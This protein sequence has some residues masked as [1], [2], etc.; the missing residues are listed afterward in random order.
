MDLLTTRSSI[1]KRLENDTSSNYNYLPSDKYT[2]FSPTATMNSSSFTNDNDIPKD[3]STPQQLSSWII[4]LIVTIS[5][6]FFLL[7]LSC[8]YCLFRQYRIQVNNKKRRRNDSNL[9]PFAVLSRT[10]MTTKNHNNSISS[11]VNNKSNA[12]SVFSVTH[13]S[14]QVEKPKKGL[15]IRLK[16]LTPLYLLSKEKRVK[17]YPGNDPLINMNDATYC[18]NILVSSPPSNNNNLEDIKHQKKT[19]SPGS[20]IYSINKNT[21]SAGNNKILSCISKPGNTNKSG[22]RPSVSFAE[23]PEVTLIRDRQSINQRQSR[24]IKPQFR[25]SIESEREEYENDDNDDESLDDFC[26]DS[27]PTITLKDILN[28]INCDNSIARE[29]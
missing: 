17:T 3:D 1:L 25:E 18:N 22:I 24:F 7:L 28:M 5:F 6:V 26:D 29:L 21:N 27:V 4:A 15:G 11:S 20:T 23:L 14:S 19:Y 13:I 16:K 8:L 9:I 12:N 2:Q 10:E